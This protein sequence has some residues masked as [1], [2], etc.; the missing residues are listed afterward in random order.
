MTLNLCKELTPEI[1]VVRTNEEIRKLVEKIRPFHVSA[2]AA[3][4]AALSPGE[5]GRYDKFLED[6]P[7]ATDWELA[8]DAF[9]EVLPDLEE[10]TKALEEFGAEE[11]GPRGKELEALTRKCRVWV[12]EKHIRNARHWIDMFGND[13]KVRIDAFSWIAGVEPNYNPLENA[14]PEEEEAFSRQ[15]KDM[16][17][18]LLSDLQESG[19]KSAAPTTGKKEDDD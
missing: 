16:F 12:V 8:L 14:T 3:A 7:D 9:G 17:K 19:A 2:E 18:G 4:D 10:L 5:P 15:A 13:S 1:G 11:A 6:W